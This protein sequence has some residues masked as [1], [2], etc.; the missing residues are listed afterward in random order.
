MA[1]YNELIEHEKNNY[2]AFES[3]YQ[4]FD[5]RFNEEEYLFLKQFYLDKD[6]I[7][8]IYNVIDDIT[9]KKNNNR[10]LIAADFFFAMGFYELF[11]PCS[12]IFKTTRNNYLSYIRERAQLNKV[13]FDTDYEEYLRTHKKLLIGLTQEKILLKQQLRKKEN[14]K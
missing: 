1:L 13:L 3:F 7:L 14:G 2:V 9:K 4:I 6:F 12:L 8:T 5:E 10:L 11:H